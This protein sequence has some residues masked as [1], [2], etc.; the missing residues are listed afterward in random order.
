M[1]HLPVLRVVPLESIR[2]HEDI[3]PLRVDRLRR[4]VTDER[5]QANPMVC[6]EAPGG[7]MVLLDGAT[8]TETLRA[9]GLRHA[10]VQLVEPATVELGT[11]HHVVRG[12]TP[13]E[14]V[15]AVADNPALNLTENYGTP[16]IHP[17]SGPSRLVEGVGGI[18]ANATLSALAASYTGRW[19]VTRTTDPHRE[20]VASSYPGWAAV[21]EFPTVGMI[22]VME[23]AVSNDLLPAG[24]TRF[25][26]PGRALRLNIPLDLLES[27]RETSEVQGELERILEERASDGR[28][29]R[30]E[31]PVFVLDD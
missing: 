13:G 29:R 30:Y 3:D 31:G 22:D 20:H 7:E 17:N 26:V 16:A 6:I 15:G 10:I 5:I 4:R 11:W 24:I 28:V 23:A 12:C 21:V 25:A 18:T 2:R 8:R 19:E 9:I 14:L 1:P 27:G